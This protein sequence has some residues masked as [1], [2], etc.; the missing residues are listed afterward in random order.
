MARRI[1]VR[2]CEIAFGIRHSENRVRVCGTEAQKSCWM[3]VFVLI[4]SEFRKYTYYTN[5]IEQ[6]VIL[7]NVTRRVIK[8][9]LQKWRR[10]ESVLTQNNIC[11][12]S[13]YMWKN[14]GEYS[15]REERGVCSS[16]LP[17]NKRNSMRFFIF[18]CKPISK[19]FFFFSFHKIEC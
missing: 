14:T 17:F 3:F 9:A 8:N 19:F 1:Y 5:R 4:W 12:Q 15:A 13:Q 2:V 6:N 10:T 18:Q 7:A 16:T 11:K